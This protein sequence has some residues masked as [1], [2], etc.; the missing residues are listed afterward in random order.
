MKK[1]FIGE[2]FL[3]KRS[4]KRKTGEDGLRELSERV[5]DEL[6]DMKKEIWEIKKKSRER[7][8]ERPVRSSKMFEEREMRLL[9]SSAKKERWTETEKR[10]EKNCDREDRPEKTPESR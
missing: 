6:Y 2:V 1:E 3:M 4:Q 5:V 9:P 10:E 8:M 7:R